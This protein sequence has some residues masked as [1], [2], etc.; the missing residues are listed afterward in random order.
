M[1][2]CRHNNTYACCSNSDDNILYC[3]LIC[4]AFLKEIFNKISSHFLFK[5]LYWLQSNTMPSDATPPYLLSCNTVQRRNAVLPGSAAK[6]TERA[7]P[8]VSVRYNIVAI[9]K[10][11]ILIGP[12]KRSLMCA[13]LSRAERVMMEAGKKYANK[14]KNSSRSVCWC[15]VA[16][17]RR[18]M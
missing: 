4:R 14:K 2:T 5:R 18:G 17:L 16:V 9:T 6:D 15:A 13:K 1:F 8:G 3:D 12:V 11:I 7:R 10:E